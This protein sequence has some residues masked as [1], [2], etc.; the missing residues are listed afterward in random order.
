MSRFVLLYI[1][2]AGFLTCWAVAEAQ[3]RLHHTGHLLVPDPYLPQLR[4][5]ALGLWIFTAVVLVAK[6]NREAASRH[7]AVQTK[8][9]ETSNRKL[10]EA[11]SALTEAVLADVD[12]KKR[13]E[14]NSMLAEYGI[15][16]R[17]RPSSPDS[18]ND[19]SGSQAENLL[20]FRRRRAP[21]DH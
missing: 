21:G 17:K 11:V 14:I 10:V 9:I 8:K 16:T 15:E 20:D 3:Y 19:Q 6:E 18:D 4:V 7:Q 5:T 1:L 13:A 2:T 12:E